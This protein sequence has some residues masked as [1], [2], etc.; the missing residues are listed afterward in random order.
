MAATITGHYWHSSGISAANGDFRFIL[1][2]EH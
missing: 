1:S 2:I